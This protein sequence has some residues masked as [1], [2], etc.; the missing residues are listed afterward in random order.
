MAKYKLVRGKK[1]DI[2]VVH[3][4]SR[5]RY[6][7]YTAMIDTG[8]IE[9][10]ENGVAKHHIVSRATETDNY[11]MARCSA[12]VKVD[13]FTKAYEDTFG[14]GASPAE[15][16]VP[17]RPIDEEID[18]VI[19]R[20]HLKNGDGSTFDCYKSEAAALKDLL[21]EYKALV[22]SKHTG[23]EF[24][25]IVR[26]RIRQLTKPGSRRQALRKLRYICRNIPNL[27]PACVQAIRMSGRAPAVQNDFAFTNQDIHIMGQSL[28]K[29]C[30]SVRA[31]Y[32]LGACR[33]QYLSD[34]LFLKWSDYFAWRDSQHGG[35][36]KKTGEP[37][38][39]F[40]WP[41]VLLSIDEKE[42][43][44]GDV[45]MFR[46]F[47]FGKRELEK[48][49][50]NKKELSP[51]EE[52]KRA[53]SAK[54]R[55]AEVFD[56]WLEQC[57]IKRQGISFRSFRYY[58]ASL[59]HAMGFPNRTLMDFF[60]W[61]K[62]ETLLL[63]ARAG[64]PVTEM[65]RFLR[66]HWLAVMRGEEPLIIYTLTQAVGVLRPM[67]LELQQAV[68]K[69]QGQIEHLSQQLA[70]NQPQSNAANGFAVPNGNVVALGASKA[71]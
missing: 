54:S 36:R 9:V 65:G 32:W 8:L 60:G 37:Y 70:G 51:A 31:L 12:Q 29:A 19:E 7:L 38:G 4:Y 62:E 46:E 17:E 26:Q 53:G 16:N 2:R 5:G 20:I 56:E 63:Y 44:P 69:V 21:G 67:I 39:G 35:N 18:A 24:E 52:A 22:P 47:V 66:E 50:C 64:V 23:P 25:R 42:Y 1:E 59:T 30:N 61:G 34:I 11:E 40:I 13:E 58:D 33:A 3:L 28:W 10:H 15:P 49:N 27:P 55:A 14:D 43:E 45:Y 68:M 57:G 41:E 48:G 71:A 6:N